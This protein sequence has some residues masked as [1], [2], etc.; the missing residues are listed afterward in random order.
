MKHFILLSAILLG[1]VV[2]MFAVL[3]SS[4]DS[5]PIITGISNDYELDSI[6]QFGNSE[7]LIFS[8]KKTD[9]VKGAVKNS[10]RT[11]STFDMKQDTEINSFI[12]GIDLT[13]TKSFIHIN[14]TEV[15]NKTLFVPRNKHQDKVRICENATS[16]DQIRAG[17]GELPS[18]T[19]EYTLHVNDPKVSITE[20]GKF[21][22]VQGIKGTGGQGEGEWWNNSYRY[23]QNLNITPNENLSTGYTMT[24]SMNTSGLVS[25]NK[26]LTNGDDIRIVFWNGTLNTEIDRINT[27]A[28]NS[29]QTNISFKLLEDIDNTSFKYYIYYGYDSAGSP[30]TNKSNIYYLWED[31]ED[32]T[33]EFTNGALNPTTSPSFAK[34][35][36][37]GLGGD[38][39]GQYRRA[40]K[41]ENLPP[42]MSIEGWVYSGY[43]GDNADLPGLEFG[44]QASE[45]NGYQ[46]I[47]DWRSESSGLADMQ[48]RLNYQSSSPLATST[49]NTVFDDTW[50]YIKTVWSKNGDINATVYDSSM[51][52]HGTLYANDNTY[53]TGYYG[54]SAY[55]DGLWDDIL[56]KLVNTPP[57]VEFTDEETLGPVIK[58]ENTSSEFVYRNE[59]I[60]ITV[61]IT[62][63]TSLSSVWINITL[64]NGNP[65]IEQMENIS[66]TYSY[67]YKATEIGNY[68]AVI[69]ANDTEGE[70][71]QSTELHWTVNGLA[72][73]ESGYLSNS[74]IFLSETTTIACRVIDINTSLGIENY[75]VGFYSNETGL[76]MFKLTNSS[77]WSSYSYTDITLGNE[78]LTCNISSN[79]SAFYNV[80][81]NAGFQ[82][83]VNTTS[84]PVITVVNHYTDL[85]DI[86]FGE[87]FTIYAEITSPNSIDTVI[88]NVTL[89]DGSTTHVIM[90]P[91]VEY[92]VQF[93]DTWQRGNYTVVVWANDSTGDTDVSNNIVKVGLFSE[94]EIQTDTNKNK[95][96]GDEDVLLVTGAQEWWNLNY[97]YRKKINLTNNDGSTLKYGYSVKLTV[98]TSDL[99]SN[100]KMLSNCD[101]LRI[102][103][104]NGT[105]RM[106]LD[107]VL[108]TSCNSAQTEV[109]FATQ[110]DIS[111]SGESGDYYL[112]YGYDSATNPPNDR[113]EV[114]LV[115]DDF[116]SYSLDNFPGN[117]WV[118]DPEFGTNDFQVKSNA[119]NKFLQS[120]ATASSYHR[121]WKGDS[122]WDDYKIEARMKHDS[123]QF[124][125]ITFRRQPFS[126]SYYDQYTMISDDRAASNKLTIR[127]WA[128][129]ASN[130]AQLVADNT[131]FDDTIWHN[132]T[133]EVIDDN[134]KVYRDGVNY[135]DYDL[136]LSSPTYSTGG[137]VGLMSYSDA[138]SFDDI[139]V[140]LLVNNE[141]DT[142]LNDEEL[143]LADSEIVNGGSRDNY[144]YLR[145]DVQYNNSGVW[146]T[147]S[148][149]LDDTANATQR[150][151]ATGQSTD[152][153]SIWTSAGGWNTKSNLSGDY[154]IYT[155]LRDQTGNILT[156]FADENIEGVS[157]FEIEATPPNITLLSP[158]NNSGD[159]G[160]LTVFTYNATEESSITSCSLWINGVVQATDTGVTSGAIE[161]FEIFE[162]D[163]GRYDWFV[164]CI[165]EFNSLGFSETNYVTIVPSFEYK[166]ETTDF[167]QVDMSD[168]QNLVIDEPTI[169]RINFTETVNL[170][171]GADINQHV[172][173]GNNLISIDSSS[174]PQLNKKAI[175]TIYGL[176]FEYPIVLKDGEFCSD[177]TIL[178]YNGDLRFSVTGFSS[179]SASPNSE[180]TV[181]DTSDNVTRFINNTIFINAE[182][183]NITSGTPITGG[184]CNVTIDSTVYTM[185]YRTGTQRY[186]Y[187]TT[188]DSVGVTPYTVSCSA[189]NF[190]PLTA[191]DHIDINAPDSPVRGNLT[192]IGSSR[193]DDSFPPVTVPGQGGNVS[194][195]DVRIVRV[196]NV[197]FGMFGNL[198]GQVVLG[199][200]SDL[201][202]EWEL[203]ES[204]EV[205]ASRSSDISFTTLTCADQIDINKEDSFLGSTG[206]SDSVNRTF[207]QTNHPSFNSSISV[208]GANS[209]PS[210]NLHSALGPSPTEYYQVLLKDGANTTVYTSITEPG[211]SGFDGNSNDFQIMMPVRENIIENYYLWVE[212]Q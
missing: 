79:D 51:N 40:V 71:S 142:A 196:T 34:N 204:G 115:W 125:G 35:G 60:K 201:F 123:F 191:N 67:N 145:I 66:S 155:T 96:G 75:T 21:F 189:L 13:K 76:L 8:S 117:G 172:I 109:W 68:S 106:Q 15:E 114:F 149:V 22:R 212:L 183:N 57:I 53:T 16:L 97:D 150:L 141:P 55:K 122:S 161:Q 69:I 24:I 210:T 129:G 154:R 58:N 99:I 208:I 205:Y 9:S 181:G 56:V 179:Y 95:Y 12:S 112:Y 91:G 168:I 73:L 195:V 49:A 101:D 160:N 23:R 52:V 113:E 132:F 84:P 163:K 83:T 171:V 120:Q 169:G 45:K 209:C 86:G 41:P 143:R 105:Q 100:N 29:E 185:Y 198:S 147:V 59:T 119:G 14:N 110:E 173:I 36:N 1:V 38:G 5:P 43:S 31:F 177:C 48:I 131:D 203:G 18:I 182:Y 87:N 166:G 158:I 176:P 199:G 78:T 46:V 157:T 121:V 98:D 61:N 88:A 7:L 211:G 159:D 133:I 62:S 74:S 184:T 32:Q 192:R 72:K 170:S 89:P 64:P 152:L 77:G 167:S 194:Q 144:G 118:D 54:I 164:T 175:L 20:D 116:E 178:S 124:A 138:T 37:Y 82:A 28:F 26:S 10:G 136:G 11:I 126:G 50:Y 63:E 165:D 180:L 39:Q 42:G 65:L 127:R 190:E 2:T 4:T 137:H 44:M 90:S 80:T 174:I 102:V 19:K 146:D 207:S 104:K 30:P 47:L 25:E 153:S 6:K 128:G 156:D 17:C 148:T 134:V 103:W 200:D 3:H 27:S 206:L 151:L 85:E 94:I 186:E 162:M 107:R 93:N 187:N 202:Y 139:K 33:S 108:E 188:I 70:I 135:I 111:G 130:Y 81:S 197:W 193:T 140:R 92:S